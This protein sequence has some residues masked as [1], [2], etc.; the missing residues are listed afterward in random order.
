MLLKSLELQGFKTFPEKTKLTFEKGITAVVGPN[1]S[2]KS[3][4]SDAMRWVLGEQSAKTLRCSRMEDVIFS[5]TPG[6]RGMNCAE[7]TLT[8][9]NA[10]RRLP[11]DGDTV[12]VT[13]RFYRSGDSEYLI[14][15]AAVRLKDI[16]ELFM[17]TGLGR[18]GYSMIGQGKIDSIVA[19]R[20]EDRREIFEEAAGVS[21]FRYRKEEAERRLAR[22]ED[23]LVRLRDIFS[24]LEGR[25]GPLKEQ[26]EK[27]EQFLAYSKEK[28]D[29][30]IRVSLAALEKSGAA[31]RQQDHKIAAAQ[32]DFDAAEQRVQALSEEAEKVFA[33]T[34]A[35]VAAMEELRTAAAADEETAARTQ[36]EAGILRGTVEHNLDTV[37]RI[38][39]E[40]DQSRLSAGELDRQIEE[41][42]Q[43]MQQKAA[44]CDALNARFLALSNQVEELRRSLDAGAQDTETLAAG[45]AA[46]NAALGELRV[47]A[48]A[49]R[50]SLEE[51]ARRGA[52]VEENTAQARRRAEEF[53]KTDSE[54]TAMAEEMQ[55]QIAGAEN[56]VQG[57]R[58]VLARREEKLQER[59]RALDE[60][61]LDV[62]GM[63]RRIGILTDME[64]SME[65]FSQAV[66]TVLREAG[67]GALRGVHGPVSRLITVPEEYALAVET[68]LGAAMQNIV[69]DNEQDAKNGIRLLKQKDAGRATFLPLTTIHGNEIQDPAFGDCPGLIGVASRVC[70]CK[71]VYRDV[72]R[73]LLGRTLLA[74]DLDAAGAIAK[75]FGY[76]WRVVTLDGQV[77]N[78][79]GSFT[80]GSSGRNA[81]ILSRGAEISRLQKERAELVHRREEAEA[82]LQALQ[83]ETEGYRNRLS[84]ALAEVEVQQEELRRTQEEIR[85]NRFESGTNDALLRELQEEKAAAARR[86]RDLSDEVARAEEK[87]EACRGRIA[88]VEEQLAAAGDARRALAE[89]NDAMARKLQELRM[90]CF[91]AA[92]EKDSLSQAA[93]ELCR[94]REE[95]NARAGEL[96]QEIDGFLAQNQALEKQIEDLTG[97]CAALRAAAA[98]KKQR[99]A[100]MSVQRMG[101]EQRAA[102]LRAEERT[103]SSARENAALE[104]ARLQERRDTLQKEYDGVIS[105]LWEEYELTRREAEQIAS[106]AEDLP[107]AQRRLTE[108]RSKIRSLGSVNVAAVEEYKEVY[109]RYTFLQEQIGDAEKA[110]TE[111]T[112]L[113]LRLTR[114]MKELFVERFSEI[115]TQFSKIFQELFGG[116]SADITI[117]DESDV[118]NSGIDIT[119]HPPG[120]IVTHIEALSGGEKALVAIAIYFAIMKVS[121]PPFCMLDEIEA[122]LDDVNVTRF[123]GYLRRMSDN[124]QFIAITHRRGTMEEADVLYGV[125]MQDQGVSQLLE[126]HQDEPGAQAAEGK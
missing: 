44:D 100:E 10:D 112:Q 97:R 28:K 114:Q 64:K 93:Q 43:A 31:L 91:A 50:S 9:E 106:P 81:G 23:N 1:G 14:N 61:R 104:L 88:R 117:A 94:R 78:A 37:A 113:I 68:A 35:L 83:K 80:G 52:Q 63:D 42:T 105:S 18:D 116:G 125:T 69:V 79:G 8:I 6:R 110:K 70:G 102:E 111:L 4:I 2:G 15:G 45:L 56:G 86:S 72:L 30:E 107:R 33:Q 98:E 24:E 99:A 126:M 62:G 89:E 119:V 32:A 103:V 124:T 90:E 16:H 76:R 121:P 59:R 7:V 96:Q 53:Q 75:R 3:N 38:R 39:R 85:R 17:D 122:A 11:F 5:G 20:S 13:R 108:L 67:R 25:V 77:V 19:A 109:E 92:T 21:R 57:L 65:G 22:A 66:K 34:N 55:Q 115:R 60:L 47:Q 71:D 84:A 120:K 101:S 27:A 51:I 54:L 123:A 26:A 74:E 82:A 87:M 41:K 73:S 46:E 12:A 95:G 48:S 49:A 40:L 36:G 118:L 29:L 58:M